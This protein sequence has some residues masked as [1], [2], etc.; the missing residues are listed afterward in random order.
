MR[1]VLIGVLLSLVILTGVSCSK[2]T[3]G[4]TSIKLSEVVRSVF[5]APQYVAISQGFFEEEGLKIE[6]STA[7]GADKGAAALVSGSVDIGF[8]GPEAAVYVYNQGAEDYLVAFAQLTK[9]DG[10]FFMARQ[11]MPDFKWEAVKNKV[12][13]G[14]RPGGVPQML[15]EHVLRKNNIKPGV[16]VNIIQNIQFTATA[17]A[18]KSGTGD[19]IQL[20][21]PTVSALEKEGVGYVVA[22][23]RVEG[24]V[25]PYTA[26]HA[27]KN[28]LKKNPEIIQRFTNAIYRG[29][30]WVQNHS[31]EEIAEAIEEF[32][33][34]IEADILLM[35]IRRY[36][37][38]DTWSQN[39]I[40]TNTAFNHLQ[41]IIQEAGELSKLVPY[42]KMVETKFAIQAI[43]DV[44][45]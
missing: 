36:K 21:E 23:F 11:P 7:W 41:T 24:G 25:I 5:Y 2:E 30:I 20:F 45:E 15:L 13:I 37:A 28:Y 40:M 31:S 22:S 3:S 27:R 14:S 33:P 1:R 18:F 10:S 12:I 35:A 6:L 42:E 34:D 32:F 8:F 16:D 4:V 44:S 17:G 38:Q 39:P 9:G 26:Y 19:F 43:K 29:Q